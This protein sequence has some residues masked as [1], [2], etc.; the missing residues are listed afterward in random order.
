MHVVLA[1]HTS[2][3]VS[4]GCGVVLHS[5]MGVENGYGVVQVPTFRVQLPHTCSARRIRAVD[6]DV[7]DN[8]AV[9][10]VA[11]ES[12]VH[13]SGF[14]DAEYADYVEGDLAL[15]RK[16]YWRLGESCFLCACESCSESHACNAWVRVHCA[17]DD[18]REH[19]A[20]AFADLRIVRGG[21]PASFVPR[22]YLKVAGKCAVLGWALHMLEILRAAHAAGVIT[23]PGIAPMPLFSNV[24]AKGGMHVSVFTIK[25]VASH[26][27]RLGNAEVLREANFHASR[28]A[29]EH[30][31]VVCYV[32]EPEHAKHVIGFWQRLLVTRV[33]D[34]GMRVADDTGKRALANFL[35]RGMDNAQSVALREKLERTPPEMDAPH[36]MP[37]FRAMRT[38]LDEQRRLW[39]TLRVHHNLGALHAYSSA[40]DFVF[41]RDTLG[42]LGRHVLYS[43]EVVA[44]SP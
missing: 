38:A 30:G 20:L 8:D 13:F 33:A 37:F 18:G 41:L 24:D 11:L 5:S 26:Y 44:A 10:S 27:A 39:A 16:G 6:R 19:E 2:G 42:T 34:S 25:T 29:S 28:M 3:V 40:C 21:S 32:P 17:D 22:L 1:R 14:D 12:P 23:D 35:S 9:A 15:A 4:H 43:T 7:T 36:L 31:P